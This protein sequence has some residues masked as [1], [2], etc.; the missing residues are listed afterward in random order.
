ME[1]DRITTSKG[2]VIHS[3]YTVAEEGNF[4]YSTT[5]IT[6]VVTFQGKVVATEEYHPNPVV[7]DHLS[8]NHN[9]QVGFEMAASQEE[10]RLKVEELELEYWPKL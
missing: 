7:V 3:H 2:F 10:A 6:Q 4:D 9:Q 8:F 1:V 5:T